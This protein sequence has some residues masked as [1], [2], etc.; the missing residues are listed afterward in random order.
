VSAGREKTQVKGTRT[1]TSYCRE[2]SR[3]R[4]LEQHKQY[5]QRPEAE[6]EAAQ[7]ETAWCVDCKA[8]RPISDFFKA[9]GKAN[10]TQS[11]CKV[12]MRE[13]KRVYRARAAR[14]RELEGKRVLY[15]VETF[16]P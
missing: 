9:R 16:T 1:A 11:V 10:G 7:P 8:R 5:I 3:A 4:A 12:H 13:R 6:I 2:C 15:D 14:S